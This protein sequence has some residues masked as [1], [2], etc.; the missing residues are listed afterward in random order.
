MLRRGGFGPL[1][2][3][4]P[5]EGPPLWTTILTGRYPRDHGIHSF[6]AYRLLGSPSLWPIL[7]KAALLA[8]V[9]RLG[10]ARRAGLTAASR[11]RRALWEVLNAFGIET[12]VV[13]FWA[14]HPPQ[15][16][17]GFLLSNAFHE[18][19]GSRPGGAS[20]LHPPDL[21][22]D[23][24]P[25]GPN[26]AEMDPALLSEFVEAPERPAAF[27]WREELVDKAL[28]PDLAYHRAGRALR[29]AYDPPFFATSVQ[30]LD[31]VG[32]VFLRYALPDRFGDVPADDAR[33]FGRVF[34]RYLELVD[35]WVGE[36][37]ARRRR[38][39]VVLVVSAHGMEPAS[40][41]HRLAEAVIGS[42]ARG[43]THAGAPEGVLLALGQ[44]IRPGASLRVATVLDVMPTVLYLMGLP[45]ARDLEGRVL[46]EMVE[47]GF[48]ATHPVSYI[49]SYE[50]LVPVPT[51]EGVPPSPP[52]P[53]ERRAGDDPAPSA[54]KLR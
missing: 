6:S 31:V 50:G 35:Q 3:L 22:A 37:L 11:R 47:A 45:V 20:P 14:T 5:A 12:G 32:H 21:L 15:R 17:R 4:R 27:P 29:A 9:E 18:A 44:G 42:D 49:L 38:D 48:A 54:R 13:R 7:P 1:G 39:E 10:L 53:E 19:P 41:P 40:L 46:G 8:Q 26:P 2:S 30:G 33:R 34:P 43:G 51:M 23:L 36:A 28:A 16:V 24:Q 52:V 25:S